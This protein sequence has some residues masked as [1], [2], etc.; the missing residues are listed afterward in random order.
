M[1]T[2]LSRGVAP[3]SR[4]PFLLRRVHGDS[5]LR[6]SV[7]MMATTAVNSLFGYIFWIVAARTYP[8]HDVG[9][10]AALISAMTLASTLSSIGIGSTLVQHMPGRS[11]GRD[12]SRTLTAGFIA[13]IASSLVIGVLALATLPLFSPQFA[14]TLRIGTYATL[15]VMSVPLWT[16]ATILDY[17]FVAERAAANMLARNLVAGL[18]KNVLLV[19]PLPLVS[20][21]AISIFSSSLV[22]SLLSSAVG[23]TLVH[24]LRSGYR[25]AMRGISDQIRTMF[26]AFLGNHLISLGG[27]APLYLLPVMVTMRL[28]AAA[29]AYFYTTWMVGGIFFVISPAVASSLLAEGSHASGSLQAKVRSSLLFITAI[30]APT[31]L[32]FLIAG[33]YILA[34]FGSSYAQHG[35]I[36]LT[37]LVASAI[38]DAI[39]NVAVSV[40]RVRRQM[41]QAAALN[42]GMAMLALILAWFLLPLFGIAGAGW[43]WLIG[44]TAGS[45]TVCAGLVMARRRRQNLGHG[46]G[47]PRSLPA[48]RNEALQAAAGPG[49]ET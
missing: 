44:Q 35:F 1:E 15:F 47:T 18:L 28:S 24:R 37:I 4:L 27:F 32:M 26:S 30:L 14:S 9:L 36:L 49:K 25:V 2:P 7:Y 19:A 6:N 11:L 20:S 41:R 21:G 16:I 17:T 33:R 39:T 5:L 29:N 38:P 48:G 3:W 34:V 10:A 8:T 45:V 43:G 46:R 42:V 23:F 40:L 13:G 22:A 12:R 31:L